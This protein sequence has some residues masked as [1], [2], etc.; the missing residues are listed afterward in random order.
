MFGCKVSCSLLMIRYHPIGVVITRYP[1][2]QVRHQTVK[3]GEVLVDHICR[4]L[5]TVRK[6]IILIHVVSGPGAPG[7][8][9]R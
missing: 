7:G 1:H 5:D 9:I 3:I 2:Y 8:P 6:R 4:S